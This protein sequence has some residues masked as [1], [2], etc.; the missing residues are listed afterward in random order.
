MQRWNNIREKLFN[1]ELWPFPLRYAPLGPLWLWYI[2]KA[3]NLWFFTP[4]DPTLTFGG[5]DGEGKKEMYN[6]LPEDLY[7]KTIYI[8][9][10]MTFVNVKR[11]VAEHGFSY[12][13]CVKPDRGLKGLLFRK[14]DHEDQLSLY[15]RQVKV[16]YLIQE[17]LEQPLEV[18]GFYYRHPAKKKGVVSG[19]VQ[20]V[21][22][23]T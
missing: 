11:L 10:D 7:P 21:N 23:R 9:P 20:S 19:F 12:P 2:I 6:L 4:A 15:H 13:F 3:K 1:W 5:F 22:F 14:V 18:S 8:K 17:L 16:D